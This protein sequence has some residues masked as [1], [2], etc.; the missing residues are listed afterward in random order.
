MATDVEGII[1]QSL[2]EMYSSAHLSVGARNSTHLFV[3][4]YVVTLSQNEHPFRP[5]VV[6]R[7]TKVSLTSL[8]TVHVMRHVPDLF[9]ASL[10]GMQLTLNQSLHFVN[11]FETLYCRSQETPFSRKRSADCLGER[12][13][14][15]PVRYCNIW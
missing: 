11:I 14:Q 7:L 10:V 12:R 8:E 15:T 2:L 3:A 13:P 5:D 4:E 6:P 1:R 9:R